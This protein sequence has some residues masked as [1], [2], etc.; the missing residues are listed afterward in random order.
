M[1]TST[2]YHALDALIERTLAHASH[3]GILASAAVCDDGGNLL[4]FR[5]TPGAEVASIVL[6]QDKAFTALSNKMSTR[7]LGRQAQP[8]G[9]LYGIA[10]NLGGRMVTFGG[11]VPVYDG[12]ALIGGI[13]VSGGTPQQDEDC[14]LAGLRAAGYSAEPR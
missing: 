8:G 2:I 12:G 9:D 7:E 13:G 4:A 5:R 3:L 14:C 6:A 11:G 10:A 1:S